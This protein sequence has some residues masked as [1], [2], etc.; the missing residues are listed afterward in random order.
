MATIWLFVEGG[1]SEPLDPP[2]GD[3]RNRFGKRNATANPLVMRIEEAFRAFLSGADLSGYTLKVTPAGGRKSAS[4]HFFA[5]VA[6]AEANSDVKAYILLIDTEKPLKHLPLNSVGEID[7]L[8]FVKDDANLF[9]KA[10][11]DG[12]YTEQWTTFSEKPTVS[13][14]FMVVMM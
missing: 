14:C 12:S 10:K 11:A 6:Q 4:N 2:P 7:Y 1:Q 5:E 8:Q 9:T 13:I 3:G